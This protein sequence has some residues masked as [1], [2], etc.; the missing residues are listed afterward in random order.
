MRSRLA[1]QGLAPP[2]ASQFDTALLFTPSLAANASCEKDILRRA[3]RIRSARLNTNPAGI[4]NSRIRC[5]AAFRN[6][7]L[8]VASNSGSA[9]NMG[10]NCPVILT[11]SPCGLANRLGSAFPDLRNCRP[12]SGPTEILA[13]T[14]ADMICSL[15]IPRCMLL[16]PCSVGGLDRVSPGI[17]LDQ[18][19]KNARS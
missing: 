11:A 5:T 13:I 2:T 19:F 1:P 9:M 15:L 7:I 6:A 4:P 16:P 3:V 17:I 12:Q 14:Q 10:K 8:R 18:R